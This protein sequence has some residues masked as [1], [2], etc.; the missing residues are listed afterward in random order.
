[1]TRLINIALQ[2]LESITHKNIKKHLGGKKGY[3]ISEITVFSVKRQASF[4][5][6]NKKKE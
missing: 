1:M 2:L 5:S 3:A 6:D 4:P